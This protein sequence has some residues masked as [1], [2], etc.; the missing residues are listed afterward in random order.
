MTEGKDDPYDEFLNK[1]FNNKK[2]RKRYDEI[3]NDFKSQIYRINF[4]DF[5]FIWD[6][7]WTILFASVFVIAL[8]FFLNPHHFPFDENSIQDISSNLFTTFVALLGLI[9]VFFIFKVQ[10]QR[11]RVGTGIKTMI[12]LVRDYS[13]K[14]STEYNDLIKMRTKCS[15][16]ELLCHIKKQNYFDSTPGL[17][18]V[19]I[20]SINQQ[21]INHIN[22][23]YLIRNIFNFTF[24]IVISFG[25]MLGVQFPNSLSNSILNYMSWNAGWFS[26]GLS[27]ALISIIYIFQTL[28]VMIF[29]VYHKDQLKKIHQ[30]SRGIGCE[31]D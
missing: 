7:Y 17:E 28:D 1:N 25:L 26:M 16:K 5:E 20:Y 10:S 12:N 18:D 2:N 22:R 13:G 29:H 23:D 24:V 4:E 9:A 30:S 11:G 31:Q 21:Y 8:F 14:T 3:T 19:W 27:Y 15:T 6:K